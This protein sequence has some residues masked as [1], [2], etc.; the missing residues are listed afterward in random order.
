MARND[1]A[2]PADTWSEA[3]KRWKRYEAEK[4]KARRE[5]ATPEAYE[6]R[7]RAALR[8]LGL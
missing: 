8:R 1:G 3:R 6:A 2:R 7:I 4:A 5:C